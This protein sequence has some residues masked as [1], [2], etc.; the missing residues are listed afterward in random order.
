VTAWRAS[1]DDGWSVV[2]GG[3]YTREGWWDGLTIVDLATG[4]MREVPVIGRP[5]AVVAVTLPA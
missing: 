5:Q 3:G 4:A 2:L 1:D